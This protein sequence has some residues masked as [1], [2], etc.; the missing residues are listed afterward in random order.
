MRQIRVL[1]CVAVIAVAVLP[2]PAS[3]WNIPGHMLSGIIAYQ[4]LQQENPATIEK[5]KTV[6]E[7]HTWY[8]NQWQAR[9]QDVPATDHSIVLFMQAD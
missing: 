1:A 6:L 9:L 2:L 7:K 8:A 3:A 5:V 4:I